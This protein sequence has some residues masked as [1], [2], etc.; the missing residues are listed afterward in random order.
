MPGFT[1]YPDGEGLVVRADVK[2]LN[3][4]DVH[5]AGFIIDIETSLPGANPAKPKEGVIERRLAPNANT[6][7]L[8]A[9]LGNLGLYPTQ[10]SA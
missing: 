1:I 6:N 9:Q 10:I 2:G 5:R 4:D 3:P 8:T 7:F